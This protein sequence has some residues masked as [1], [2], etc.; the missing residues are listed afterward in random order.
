MQNIEI[1]I[2]TVYELYAVNRNCSAHKRAVFIVVQRI[3]K[4]MVNSENFVACLYETV[5]SGPGHKVVHT[6]FKTYSYNGIAVGPG[7]FG[8]RTH[9]SIAYRLHYGIAPAAVS[10][11][12]VSKIEHSVVLNHESAFV[13][14]A[15]ERAARVVVYPDARPVFFKNTACF[16]GITVII[17]RSYF[18]QRVPVGS[19]HVFHLQCP[20]MVTAVGGAYVLRKINVKVAAFGKERTYVDCRPYSQTRNGI[21]EF[22]S[23][24][25]KLIGKMLSEIYGR[26]RLVKR[27]SVE[28]GSNSRAV[29]SFRSNHSV[30]TN[31]GVGYANT[32]IQPVIRVGG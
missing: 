20:Y 13:N 30:R 22:A 25:G 16:T 12:R 31:G 28:I 7:K 21:H 4:G 8:K 11:R 15:V 24:P 3:V 1:V 23:L 9:R 5:M 26:S 2:R 14:V 6:A 32:E 18:S 29:I 10:E 27:F 17:G 19:N